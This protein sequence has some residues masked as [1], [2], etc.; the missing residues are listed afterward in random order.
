MLPAADLDYEL[1]ALGPHGVPAAAPTYLDGW[2]PSFP[3]RAN[4]S[5][6]AANAPMKSPA[7][8]GLFVL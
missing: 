4:I 3:D 7:N 6:T 1:E 2:R 5:G 8:A